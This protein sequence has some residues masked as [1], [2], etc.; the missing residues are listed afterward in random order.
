MKLNVKDNIYVFTRLRLADGEPM[1]VETS[2]VP[3][4]RFPDLTRMNQKNMLCDIFT[5][6]YNAEFTCA[7]ETFQPVLTR[8]DEAKLLNYFVGMPSMMIARL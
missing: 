7:E 3:Y 6:K 5:D 8:E 1:M 2:Y 4:N